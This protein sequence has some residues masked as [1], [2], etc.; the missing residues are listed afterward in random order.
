M[1]SAIKYFSLVAMILLASCG[2]GGGDAGTNPNSPAN[3]VKPVASI[4]Y[5]LDKSTITN[6][7]ADE[8]TIVVTAL[9]ASN[10]PVSGAALTV[11]LDS[12]IYTPLVASTDASGRASEKFLQEVT[13]QIAILVSL[14]LL[15]ERRLLE[16]FR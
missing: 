4:D 14:L 6:S 8:A 16:C 7:G 15:V 5:Q 9:D 1:R 13:R 12:G 3:P 11:A 10:N 2:G